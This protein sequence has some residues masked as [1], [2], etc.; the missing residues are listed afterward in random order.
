MKRFDILTI[1]P[2]SLDSYFNESIL[3][4]AQ[5]KKL[6]SIKTHDL[7]AVAK[8]KH[9]TVDDKPYGGGPGMVMKIDIVHR[10]LQKLYPKPNKKTRVIL[11][12]TRGRLYDQ[13][14]AKRLT[15]YD[16]LI[17]IAGHYEAIDA[18]IDD[19]VD[20]KI[21][22]GNFV[23]TGGELAAAAVIDSLARLIPGVV[24][25]AAS[26]QDESFA[27]FSN[28]RVNIEYPQYTR[29]FVY[30]KLKVPKVLLSGDHQKIG[31]WRRKKTK[32][33]SV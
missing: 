21:C 15:K 24:G 32:R 30:K 25:K 6:I 14:Q 26:V 5:T 22:L 3:K 12:S 13:R 7:R 1:F 27:T 28:G 4:R 17:L 16:R 8:D 2:H 18:R 19:F 31:S 11:L 10:A 23:L 9:K 20:E 29:P 33:R